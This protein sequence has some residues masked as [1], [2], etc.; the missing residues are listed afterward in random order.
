[1]RNILILAA[2]PK[3]TSPL[4]LDQEIRDIQEGLQR[5]KN[6]DQF[7]LHSR[8]AVRPRDI[9]RAMLDIQPQIIHF[10]GH[11]VGDEGLVFEDETG[12]AKF[13]TGEALA[14]LFQLFAN[15]IECIVLNG[16]YSEVQA[17]A[18]TRHVPYVIG[19]NQAIGDTAAIEF[20]V[21]FYDALGAGNSVEFSYRSGCTAIQLAGIP[22][23]LIPVLKKNPDLIEQ[24]AK[25]SAPSYSPSQNSQDPSM[26]NSKMIEVF[27][28]YAREDERLAA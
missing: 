21:G 23:H 19:M 26:S 9:Q 11:G 28:S 16:C 6:R 3:S 18:I 4:R 20:A 25:S 27:I 22:Q 10:C 15:Y 2:N 1:M 8:Q 17:E 13:I 7:S 5:S 14:S 24:P 12:Q